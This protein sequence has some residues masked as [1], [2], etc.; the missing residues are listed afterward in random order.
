MVHAV[1][2]HIR[3]VAIHLGGQ[4][5][6]EIRQYTRI[7]NRKLSEV[8]VHPPDDHGRGAIAPIAEADMVF[9][10]LCHSDITCA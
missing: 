10:E 5:D 6:V 3:R 8:E 1:Q 7:T 2:D 4:V 9:L